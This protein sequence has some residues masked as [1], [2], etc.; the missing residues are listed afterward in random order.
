MRSISPLTR[1]TY[2]DVFRSLGKNARVMAEQ[3]AELHPNHRSDVVAV[4][5]PIWVMAPRFKSGLVL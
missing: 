5:G 2:R 1:E 4:E 3:M